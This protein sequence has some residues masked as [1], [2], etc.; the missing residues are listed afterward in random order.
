MRIDDIRPVSRGN[1][2][3][4]VRQTNSLGGVQ[5]RV[6]YGGR[7]SI[8]GLIKNQVPAQSA[9]Q[10]TAQRQE[11]TS[12]NSTNASVETSHSLPK[13]Q[14]LT[15]EKK[16]ELS[17]LMTTKQKRKRRQKKREKLADVEKG[18]ENTRKLKLRMP[19]TWQ[20]RAFTTLIIL[21]SGV[22]IYVAVDTWI[23]NQ[24]VKKE[25]E[26]P[27]IVDNADPQSRQDAE[28]RDE[29]EVSKET[30]ADYKVAANLPR[31]LTVDKLNIK[32]RILPMEVNPDNSMQAPLN[33]YD[34]GWYTA[35]AKPGEDG[36]VVM[37][38]HASGPTREGLFAYLD[39]LKAGDTMTIERGDGKVF[40][41]E[42]VHVETVALDKIDMKKFLQ[43]YD[44]V[45]KG[46]NLMT[47]AGSWM[48]ERKTFDQRSIVYAKQISE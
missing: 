35:S 4:P 40:T 33:I 17:P 16:S 46:L 22:V 23:T 24:Q 32:A 41:Y 20:D 25:V 47:C 48:K 21:L 15:D 5:Q 31:I 14:P 29:T 36:A 44:G 39:T 34:S 10:Q 6:A 28:G 30:L 12:K 8:D 37:D 26:R 7:A 38:G 13:M 43:P 1:V 19:K 27:V 3:P 18:P 9:S 11:V 45:S 42:V 2:R